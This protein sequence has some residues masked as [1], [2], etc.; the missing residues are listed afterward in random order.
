MLSYYF[1]YF[2]GY[3]AFI[4]FSRISSIETVH[5]LEEVTPNSP[6][7][8]IQNPDHIRNAIGLAFDFKRQILFYS[9]VQLG[10]ISSVFFNNTN[11]T[12]IA[13]KQGSVEGLYFEASHSDLYWTCS[14]DASINR[15]NPYASNT[16][17]EKILKLSSHDKPR[18]IA[19]DVCESRLYWTNWDANRPSIQRSYMSGFKVESIIDTDI[20]MPNGLTL[21]HAAK[22]LYWVDARLDK[23][24]RADFDGRN[25]LVIGKDK[26]KHA[27]AIAVFED[28]IYWTDW[29]LFS[30]LRANK[31]TG[32]DVVV[33]RKDIQK[34]MGIVAVSNQTVSCVANP[35]NILNGGC[36][37]VCSVGDD[38]KVKCSCGKDKVMVDDRC[39]AKHASST[40]CDAGEFLCVSGGCINYAL[41]CDGTPH[42]QDGSDESIVYCATRTCHPGF[43]RCR[44]N[45]CI[46]NSLVCNQVT[47]SILQNSL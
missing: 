10:T 29:V 41:T 31:H 4:V 12:V 5:V 32:D 9:D 3:D 6:Y 27:F 14:N 45:R 18:G 25:R 28:Y 37:D 42:C 26:P 13:E 36:S 33:L 44:S 2:A 1:N 11:Y 30:V 17:V 47:Q 38:G 46:P 39:V 24:E 15:L 43:F 7:P 23:I 20:R 35:C 22:K 16:K 8:P 21:D 40:T 34:P 19:V